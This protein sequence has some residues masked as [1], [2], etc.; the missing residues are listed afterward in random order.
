MI[1][2][3]IMLHRVLAKLV[4]NIANIL[5]QLHYTYLIT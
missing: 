1:A 2:F 3:V 5:F 4:Y